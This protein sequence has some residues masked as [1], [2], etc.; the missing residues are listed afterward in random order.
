MDKV[1]RSVSEQSV[2]IF[3]VFFLRLWGKQ[4]SSLH[5]GLENAYSGNIFE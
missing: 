4:V 3:D 5:T 1:F 2:R